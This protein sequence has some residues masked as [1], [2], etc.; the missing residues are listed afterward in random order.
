[1]EK[2]VEGGEGY[3]ID[4]DGTKG[5][6]DNFYKPKDSS[7]DKD[8]YQPGKPQTTR[9]GYHHS[10]SFQN[11]AVQPLQITP[12]QAGAQNPSTLYGI[13]QGKAASYQ[14]PLQ[15][16]IPGYQTVSYKVPS[17]S[18]TGGNLATR[19][20]VQ[21][22]VLPSTHTNSRYV[23]IAPNTPQVVSYGYVRSPHLVPYGSAVPHSNHLYQGQQFLSMQVPPYYQA[24]HG[25]PVLSNVQ[26]A[27][28]SMQSYL[29]N[30]QPVVYNPYGQPYGQHVYGSNQVYPTKQQTPGVGSQYQ[31]YGQVG[32]S[33]RATQSNY[34]QP[35]KQRSSNREVD[36]YGPEA[37]TALGRLVNPNSNG[38]SLEIRK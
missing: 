29:T 21:P 28:T 34:Q 31:P 37:R 13:P 38:F 30:G 9:H 12:Y 26:P 14:K 3:L 5:G 8:L 7:S 36:E 23:G 32:S 25:Q 15:S 19:S 24:Y 18:H 16:Y 4:P 35:L 27:V 17:Q 22:L 10:T 6:F 1:M 20:L 2:V 11:Q 33:Y